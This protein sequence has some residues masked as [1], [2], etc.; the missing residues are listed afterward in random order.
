ML[1]VVMYGDC[2]EEL[3]DIGDGYI[4]MVLVDLPYEI[5]KLKWDFMLSPEFMISEFVRITK[6]GGAIVLFGQE[7]FSSKMRL[8]GL[9]YYKYDWIWYKNKPSGMANAKDRPMC[10][11]ENIMVF[12]KGRL[13][14]N[15]IKESRD[16]KPESIQLSLKGFERKS[17]GSNTQGVKEEQ[18]KRTYEPL[19]NPSTVKKFDVVSNHKGNRLHPTQKPVDLCE[20]LVRTH[21]NEG[22]IVFDPTAGS[23]TTAVACDNTKRNWIC[24][25]KD[26]TYCNL[27]FNRINENR[28]RLQIRHANKNW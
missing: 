21:S 13:V 26:L 18:F 22:D 28:D 27:G 23:F 20:Y 16:L 2:L 14:F 7:P 12:G 8:A 11:H 4:D 24:I 9:E 25:E 10:N 1:N 5:T 15:P 6:D 3:R 19:R 17:Y